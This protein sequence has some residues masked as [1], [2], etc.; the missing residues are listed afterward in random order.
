MVTKAFSQNIPLKVCD[1]KLD[2]CALDLEYK[3]G[4]FT[5]IDEQT[6]IDTLIKAI[7]MLPD[8]ISIQR[9]TAGSE[10]LLAPQWCKNKSAQLSHIHKALRNAGIKL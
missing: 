9:M 5:P 4:N 8:N 10:N 1:L 2:G 3:K 7:K 6:Y